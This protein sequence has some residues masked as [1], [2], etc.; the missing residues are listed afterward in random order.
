VTNPQLALT[1]M[2]ERGGQGSEVA[3]PIAKH[4]IDW[5]EMN[6]LPQQARKAE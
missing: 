5:W 6:R 2:V 3:A 4:I 1:V